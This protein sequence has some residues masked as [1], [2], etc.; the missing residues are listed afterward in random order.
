M[1]SD[2]F[3]I[4]EEIYHAALD[5]SP[6][7]RALFL[8]T[9]CGGDVELKKEIEALLY[10]EENPLGF[11]DDSPEDLAAELFSEN[12]TNKNLLD[13]KIGRYKIQKILGEGGMGTVYLARDTRLARPVALKIFP[14]ELVKNEDRLQRFIHEARSASALNH[15]H[16][17][18]VYEI[19]EFVQDDGET[20]HFIAMEFVDGRTLE[21][22]IYSA[23]IPTEDLLKYLAQ[24]A[25]GLS[26]AH[27]AGIIHRDLKPENIMVSDD[28][29]A[30]ILDFG[31]AK[32]T[33]AENEL[34]QLQKHK[35]RSGVILGTLGYMSPEQAQ[36]KTD[37]DERSD[38]FSFGCI[39]YE[40][41]TKK[42]AFEAE[43]TIDALYKIIH[44]EPAPV[45]DFFQNISPELKNLL[46]KCLAKS[47]EKRFQKIK[48]AATILQKLSLK[49]FDELQNQ[50]S[51]AENK[52]KIFDKAA[53]S[54]TISKQFSAQRRQVTILFG[55]F[56]ALNELL[57][58][59]D[60]EEASAKLRNLWDLFDKI[61]NK[62][63]GKIGERLNDTFIAI[64][65]TS[66]L[67]E[68]DPETAV[69]AALELRK[70]VTSFFDKKLSGDFEADEIE[71]IEP[72]KL[73]KIGISTG[74][75]LLGQS[76]DTGEFV[77]TG[78]P[79]N[80]ARRILTETT[81]GKIHISHD[82]YRHIR[83]IFDVE[84]VAEKEK[85]FP[86]FKKL[87]TKIYSINGIKP[88]AFRLENRGVEGI[89]TEMFGR[90]GEIAKMLDV[91]YTVVEERELQVVT[92]VGEAG[93][94]KSRLLFEIQDK[95][96][97]LPEKFF[98]FKA[99]ALESMRGLPYSLVRDLFAFR[100]EIGENDSHL[101]AR[102]KF[103]AGILEMISGTNGEFAKEA[104]M[105]AHFI[106]HLLGFDFSKSEF[107]SEIIDDEKQIQERAFQYSA[108]FFSAIS[109]KFP[110]VIYLDDLH[111]ADNESLDFF[112]VL[113]EN[114][115]TDAILIFETAR[116]ILFERKPHRGE[117]KTNR[118]RLNLQFLTKR[119]SRQL[120]KNIL[121]KAETIPESL[122]DLIFQNTEGN[123]FYVEELIKMLIEQNVIDSRGETWK[124]HEDQLNK[125]DVP[126][127]L[128][129][130]LQSR[131]DKLAVSEKRIL[132]RASVIGREFWEDALKKFETE[133]NISTVL[134]SLRKKELLFRRESSAFQNSKE[135]IFKHALLR[136]VT[137][138]TVLLQERQ[139]WHAETARWLIETSGE[140]ENEYLAV[141]AEH[142]EKAKKT[143]ESAEW[144]GRAGL[145][146]QKSYAVKAAEKYFRKALHYRDYLFKN[147]ELEN[148]SLTRILEWKKGLTR[149]L[150]YQ[151]KFSEAISILEE[152][153]TLAEQEKNSAA[154]AWAFWSLSVSQFENGDTRDS[155][156]SAKRAVEIAEKL[157]PNL[158]AKVLLTKGLYR[159]GRALV[160]LG[161]FENAINL[162][163]RAL[164]ISKD[165]GSENSTAKV[166]CFHL[167]SASNM[168]LG[169]LKEA[170]EFEEKL[171]SFSR[172]AGDIRTIGNGLNTL[173]FQSY[174]LGDAENA[175]KYFAESLEIARESGSKPSEIMIRS[176]MGGAKIYLGEY[177]SA[178]KELKQIISEVGEKGH[179]VIH[180][181]HRFLAEALIGQGKFGEA[182]ETAEKALRLAEE[183]ES[184]EETGENWRILGIISSCTKKDISIKNQL[185]S[186]ADCFEKSLNI[187]KKFKMEANYAQAMHNFARH[188]SKHGDAEKSENLF[189]TAKEISQ[190]LEIN[191]EAKNIYFNP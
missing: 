188:E 72:K 85:N 100:F 78:I 128:T 187:F 81:F 191:T 33:D 38:I 93:L 109:K 58:D 131:L 96:E 18:T 34:H 176:N 42:K 126:P 104:E 49:S 167:L 55:N 170:R 149:A 154:Q 111:W 27:S 54:P 179:F 99:R 4:I 80:S 59:F 26:K 5:F 51:F 135:Y 13:K 118:L 40:A 161:E 136:D 17:L 48:D 94:G 124:I 63:G 65:G 117:G 86:K 163:N 6:E 101:R 137:Y 171:I 119:Q 108:Q 70:N 41:I 37:I 169:R 52:T 79:V 134:E 130:V 66:A 15:P 152:L 90:E 186:A 145:Q 71:T 183:A 189:D 19:D 129:G 95:L 97:L 156:E 148:F 105:K 29:Y 82:T 146:A 155:L 68:N 184:I 23:K 53:T 64:W 158:E 56:T 30:K 8:E 106:G 57:E 1:N 144:F 60:P 31:L 35:S 138:E 182:L 153:K 67:S 107:L 89:E 32:L 98:V 162:A 61:I 74:T 172:K 88:R 150:H 181:T 114:C 11:I 3:K 77:T 62:N 83:G 76:S 177:V 120:I 43:T 9:E 143:Q 36:G 125:I 165:F 166:N 139:K 185:Y 45:T 142:F 20:I 127:T 2:R 69:R 84:E 159:Q 50:K 92:I 180:E 157:E 141:I 46:E 39:L 14:P 116:P 174:M 121:Q 112:E 132:Q 21:D 113:Y 115:A 7:K 133:V 190:R 110:V 122:G 168:M 28:G 16:I 22:L 103:V 175:V 12:E 102:E 10:F 91:F 44:S 87:Q 24:V 25:E 173:G 75:V 140:R 151:T 123:P 147:G 73:L 164:E 178:E 47:P 160:G